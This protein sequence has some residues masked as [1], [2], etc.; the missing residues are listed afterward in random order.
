MESHQDRSFVH[1][2]IPLVT[3][4]HLLIPGS[5][6]HAMVFHFCVMDRCHASFQFPLFGVHTHG[7]AIEAQGTSERQRGECALPALIYWRQAATKRVERCR[8]HALNLSPF[9]RQVQASIKVYLP[10]LCA[11]WWY[12]SAALS[13]G[14]VALG[15]LLFRR[16]VTQRAA[17]A[18]TLVVMHVPWWHSGIA[19]LSQL[20]SHVSSARQAAALAPAR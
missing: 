13:R 5:H 12:A 6:M 19:C 16:Q 4:G 20:D 9:A 10:L 14:G 2:S 3:G 18:V 11:S 17:A 8:A 15:T 7:G 1:C